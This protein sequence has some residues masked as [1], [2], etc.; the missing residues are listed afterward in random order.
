MPKVLMH[1]TDYC[2]MKSARWP[3]DILVCALRF[4]IVYIDLFFMS[5]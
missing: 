2:I 1:S 3:G 4:F 5:E